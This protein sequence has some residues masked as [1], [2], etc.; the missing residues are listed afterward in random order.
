MVT[1]SFSNLSIKSLIILI[2]ILFGTLFIDPSSVLAFEEPSDQA[3]KGWDYLR[4]TD[5]GPV[6]APMV[7]RMSKMLKPS[8]RFSE[9][10]EREDQ[11]TVLELDIKSEASD[12]QEILV[13]FFESPDWSDQPA[14]VHSFPGPGQYTLKDIPPGKYHLGAVMGMTADPWPE[15]GYY[16]AYHY[17]GMKSLPP[18]IKYIGV[19]ESWPKPISVKTNFNTKSELLLSDTF[20]WKDPSIN[21][22]TLLSWYGNWKHMDPTRLVTIKTIDHEGKVIPFCRLTLFTE[23]EG[24]RGR[25]FKDM[26]TDSLGYGYCDQIDTQFSISMVVQHIFVPDQLLKISQFLRFEQIYNVAERPVIDIILDPIPIGNSKVTGKIHD[27]YGRP[28]EEFYLTIIKEEGDRLGSRDYKEI[29]YKKPFSSPDGS[30]EMN[31]LVPGDYKMRARAFDYSAYDWNFFMWDF[32]I[33]EEGNQ[34]IILDLTVEAKKLYYGKAVYKDDTPVLKGS[35]KA[36]YGKE[37]HDYD[38]LRLKPDGTFKVSISGEE[39]GK[40]KEYSKGLITIKDRSGNSCKVEI[41]ELSENQNSPLKIILS[42]SEKPLESGVQ[43]IKDKSKYIIDKKGYPVSFELYDTNGKLFKLEDHKGHPVLLYIFT[44][45]CGPCKM[46]K[47]Y[48]KEI[49]SEWQ[50]NGL[51]VIAISRGEDPDIVED[52][53]RRENPPYTVL[54]DKNEKVTSLFKGD[55]GKVPLPTNILLDKDHNVVFHQIGFN[56]DLSAILTAQINNILTK[57]PN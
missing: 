23:E 43:S 44:T 2:L 25:W 37:K 17:Q 57:S 40:L 12:N 5:T 56:E 1:Y 24:S 49:I 54:V 31:N 38:S 4:L 8:I 3:L 52:Y 20:K 36:I 11:N 10:W 48:L 53:V 29:N 39:Y 33:P 18:K 34:E 19:N 42:G 32:T 6:L 46:E 14:H 9:V 21:S 51:E 41:D 15:A 26:G 28:L 35:W 7:V 30:F 27:Q 47:G 50:K 22:S 16:E 13:G 55:D 45:W